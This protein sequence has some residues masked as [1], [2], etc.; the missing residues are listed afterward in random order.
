MNRLAFVIETDAPY[1]EEELEDLKEAFIQFMEE[2]DQ[3]VDSRTAEIAIADVDEKPS[4]VTD[5]QK[6]EIIEEFLKG[7]V[8]TARISIANDEGDEIH[9][10]EQFGTMAA[11]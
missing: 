4:L 6:Q 9:V 11:G 2:N 10:V 5:A 8:I 3:D 1:S 7:S